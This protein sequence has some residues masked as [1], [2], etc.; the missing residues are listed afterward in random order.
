MCAPV[1]AEYGES[2]VRILLHDASIDFARAFGG[3]CETCMKYAQESAEW[4]SAEDG[5][6]MVSA[7]TLTTD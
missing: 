1:C 4:P 7:D 3:L 5:V 2:T 6:R